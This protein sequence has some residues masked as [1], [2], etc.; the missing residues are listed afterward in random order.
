M[1]NGINVI[2]PDDLIEGVE[3]DVWGDR[4]WQWNLPLPEDKNP[5]GFDDESDP[6]GRLGS[7]EKSQEAQDDDL[8]YIATAFSEG[9]EGEDFP[10][11]NRTI[12]LPDDQA[13]KPIF[14][15][16]LNVNWRYGENG[17]L[18]ELEEL[19]DYP[20]SED[21]LTP[22]EIRI[23]N[24]AII[25]EV[26]ATNVIL[27]QEPITDRLP[28][29]IVF[30]DS[31]RQVSPPDSDGDG[32]P[33][34]SFV[35]DGDVEESA[36]VGEGYWVALEPLTP[37]AH[38]IEFG[39]S[40]DLTDIAIDLNQDGEVS[41]DPQTK[42]GYVNVLLRGFGEITLGVTYN[43]LNQ[44]IGTNEKDTLTGTPKNDYID[45][46]NGRDF[47]SGKAGN[48]LI[49][50]GKGRDN[51]D[52]GIGDDELWGE[53]GNDVFIYRP[54]Y[55]KD[56]IYDFEP[57]E[58]IKLLGFEEFDDEEFEDSITDITLTS[59]VN[60]AQITFN[61]KD[62]LHIVGVSKNDLEIDDGKITFDD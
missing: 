62:I 23:I 14:F 35:L 19:G 30:P 46:G 34:F 20:P 59:G 17:E 49:L 16:V 53:E 5:E 26:V 38:T 55:G 33:G 7:L 4:W 44:I 51:I 8:F 11:L 2:S 25:D 15:P 42:E 18:G 41:T 37:G 57:G 29:D 21:P 52:G 13:E 47:L 56:K 12:I 61:D 9:A 32:K 54:G 60:A 58:K 40:F 24:T 36:A 50:G 6:R 39:G 45:G 22:D 27:D 1:T 43:I 28:P 3:Q 31:F 48:D 10:T